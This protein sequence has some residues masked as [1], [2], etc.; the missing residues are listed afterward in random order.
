M[1]GT[2]RRDLSSAR[3]LHKKGQ[4]QRMANYPH[5][6]LQKAHLHL[7]TTSPYF[8]RPSLIFGKELRNSSP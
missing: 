6:W 3:Y 4:Y 5:I 1:T 8:P 7:T 2:N